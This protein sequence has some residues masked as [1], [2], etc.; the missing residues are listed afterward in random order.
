MVVFHRVK[1]FLQCL[2]PDKV[3]D[4]ANSKWAKEC[5]LQPV[6]TQIQMKTK[7]SVASLLAFKTGSLF[8]TG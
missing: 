6:L 5:V 7:G 4:P 8:Q 3:P 2:L 1:L